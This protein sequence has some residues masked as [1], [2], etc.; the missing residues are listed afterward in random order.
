M[1]RLY[2]RVC[3]GSVWSRRERGRERDFFSFKKKG[4]EKGGGGGN[5]FISRPLRTLHHGLP[6]EELAFALGAEVLQEG[7][8]VRGVVAEFLEE[9]LG[10]WAGGAGSRRHV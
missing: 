1:C 5:T 8:G 3:R 2:S 4:R 10:G 9:T 6:F 7:Q